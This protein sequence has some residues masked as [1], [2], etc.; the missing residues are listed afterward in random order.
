MASDRN[1]RQPTA[2]ALRMALMTERKQAVLDHFI[3]DNWTEGRPGIEPELREN[4]RRF[5]SR[6]LAIKRFY[7]RGLRKSGGAGGG[8]GAAQGPKYGR[9]AFTPALTCPPP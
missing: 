8:S 7:K 2:A 5:R 9:P 4:L 3:T 1:W 6:T